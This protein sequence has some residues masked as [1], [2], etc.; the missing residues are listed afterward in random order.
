MYPL[1]SPEDEKAIRTAVEQQLQAFQ[2][3]DALKA[4]SLACPAL[5]R[6]FRHANRF[7]QMVKTAYYPVYR[8]RAVVFEGI[9]QL[10]NQPALQIMVMAPGGWLARAIYMMQQQPDGTWRIAGCQLVPVGKG[11][12]SQS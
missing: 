10:Q 8:P 6:Q 5:Q 1:L 9:T 12:R 7:M 4:F 2:K 11:K 3:D